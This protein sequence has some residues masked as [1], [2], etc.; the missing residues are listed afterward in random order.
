MG[1][2]GTRE[3]DF[4]GH[5]IPPTQIHSFL[6]SFPLVRES[7]WESV[8]QLTWEKEAEAPAASYISSP[9]HGE[10]KAVSPSSVAELVRLLLCRFS[11]SFSLSTID[12][13]AKFLDTKDRSKITCYNFKKLQFFLKKCDLPYILSFKQKAS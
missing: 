2:E 6:L 3:Y 9:G 8:E 13:T 7:R 1:L 12:L 10:T 11:P 4:E 5:P